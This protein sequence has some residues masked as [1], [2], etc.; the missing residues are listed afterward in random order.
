MCLINS[1]F[2]IIIGAKTE[3]EIINWPLH[4]LAG[5]LTL[6]YFLKQFILATFVID[7]SSCDRQHLPCKDMKIVMQKDCDE[8]HF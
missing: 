2:L 1:V 6:P 3:I 7:Y 5:Y 4:I 8:T